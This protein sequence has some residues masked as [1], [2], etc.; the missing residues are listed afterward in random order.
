MFNKGILT[1]LLI[2]STLPLA[3]CLVIE[4]DG[5]YYSGGMRRGPPPPPQ[6]VW[7]DPQGAGA[8]PHPMG[9]GAAIGDYCNSLYQQYPPPNFG[10]PPPRRY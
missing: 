6:R 8:C 1:A 5:G 3:G 7:V 9:R 2:G 10:R 4:E